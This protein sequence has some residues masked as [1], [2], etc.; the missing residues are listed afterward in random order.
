[1][2]VNVQAYFVDP[3]LTWMPAAVHGWHRWSRQARPVFPEAIDVVGFQQVLW[4]VLLEAVGAAS[5]AMVGEGVEGA[6]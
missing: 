2:Q 4:Y 1:V 5:W 3:E 6:L